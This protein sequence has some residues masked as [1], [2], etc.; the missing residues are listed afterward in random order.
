MKTLAIQLLFLGILLPS[1]LLTGCLSDDSY[2]HRQ[3]S[4]SFRKCIGTDEFRALSDF[5]TAFEHFLLDN[6]YRREGGDL[7]AAYKRY[8][9]HILN[10]TETDT[11]WV[12]RHDELDEILQRFEELHIDALL[13]RGSIQLC[14][15]RVRY[16]DHMLMSHFR[17]IMP[18][19]TVSPRKFAEEFLREITPEETNDKVLRMMLALEYFLGPVLNELRPDEERRTCC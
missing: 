11:S 8:L 17:E 7:T 5:A 3:A 1:I 10:L 16:P 18:Q 12:F 4:E 14:A 15:T 2:S 13:Y 6:G 19:H 9:R